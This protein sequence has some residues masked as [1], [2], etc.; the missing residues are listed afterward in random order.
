L[1]VLVTGA[2]GFIGSALVRDL[3]QD[4][5]FS[6]RAATRRDVPVLAGVER[7]VVGDFAATADWHDAV[8][9]VD[10]VVHLAGL[11]HVRSGDR[12][13]AKA[14][15]EINAVAATKLARQAA[16]YGVSRFVF[17]SSIKV[18][19]EEG[20][21]SE[22]DRLSPGDGYATSKALAEKSLGDVASSMGMELV[23]IRPPLVYGD[24]A[25]AN[26]DLLAGA[27]R[28]G[29]PLP[30]GGISNRRSLVALENV[31]DFIRLAIDHPAAANQAFLVSD[32]EDLSTSELVRRIARAMDKPARLFWIPPRLV[33]LVSRSFGRPEFAQRLLGS[34]WI[35]SSKA[36]RVLGWSAPFSVDDALRRT[37]AN[38]R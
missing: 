1:R 23:I 32:A 37:F 28:S 9:G 18:H 30:L 14:F 26:F 33:S 35:S 17:L 3:V 24:G 19:G 12:R 16:Q 5:R 25:K 21:F 27:I 2:T 29:V 38:S 4:G 13:E 15:E 22:E 34:L 10:V 31:I 7:V 11:A 8:A 20:S 36:E 6:L